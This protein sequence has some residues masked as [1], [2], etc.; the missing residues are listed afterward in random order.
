M[1]SYMALVV[2]SLDKLKMIHT[3]VCQL[4]LRLNRPFGI[5]SKLCNVSNLFEVQSKSFMITTIYNSTPSQNIAFMLEPS[6]LRQTV[7]V[8]KPDILWVVMKFGS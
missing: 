8:K 7:T 1:V 5:C 3:T 2:E 6:N 4:R